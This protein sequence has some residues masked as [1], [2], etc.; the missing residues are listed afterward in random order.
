MIPPRYL[1]SAYSKQGRTADQNYK[2]GVQ[3]RAQLQSTEM[4]LNCKAP[5]T[6]VLSTFYEIYQINQRGGQAY[7][8]LHYTYDFYP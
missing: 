5:K 2:A 6:S 3:V 1:P 8:V 7:L 4:H